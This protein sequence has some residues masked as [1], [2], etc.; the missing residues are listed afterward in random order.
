MVLYP[1]LFN[2]WRFL[3]DVLK[4]H[5]WT[6]IICI[7]GFMF[8]DKKRHGYLCHWN[9]R[10]VLLGIYPDCGW[11]MTAFK[12][13]PLSFGQFFGGVVLHELG[14]VGRCSAYHFHL[15]STWI[16]PRKWRFGSIILSC[17]ISHVEFQLS[18][19][20]NQDSNSDNSFCPPT[21][22]KFCWTQERSLLLPLNR[23]N[24]HNI[25]Q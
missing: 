19:N 6:G 13:Y 5:V 1:C 22:P 12:M 16:I 15:T 9:H 14:F 25:I 23:K 17:G 7:F 8:C 11:R 3:W 18:P 4:T 21:P 20:Q 24:K 10:M 2:G